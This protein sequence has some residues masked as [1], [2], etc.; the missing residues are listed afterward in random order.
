MPVLY[1]AKI[2]PPVSV[3][4]M[5]GK[6][7]FPRGAQKG[8]RA[9][10]LKARPNPCNLCMRGRKQRRW[11]ERPPAAIDAADRPRGSC[12]GAQPH[13]AWGTKDLRRGAPGSAPIPALP[14]REAPL[15]ARS[16]TWRHLRK[17]R[18]RFASSFLHNELKLLVCLPRNTFCSVS[19]GGWGSA[20]HAGWQIEC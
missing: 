16:Q 15:A 3:A 7:S 8:Y 13:I 5:G 17:K 6:D 4:G 9:A 1:L 2:W 19:S 11:M 14:P 18:V 12:A 10:N 20:W